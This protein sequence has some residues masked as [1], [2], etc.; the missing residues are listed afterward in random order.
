MIILTPRLFSVVLFPGIL[1]FIFTD[2]N[3]KDTDTGN[4]RF[5]PV[6]QPLY[7]VCLFVG[8]FVIEWLC[9]VFD[10]LPLRAP[11]TTPALWA[12]ILHICLYFTLLLPLLPLLRRRCSARACAMLWLL[13]NEF[14]FLAHGGTG[15]PRPLVVLPIAAD[16]T[17]FLW[18]WGVGAGPQRCCGYTPP[19]PSRFWTTAWKTRSVAWHSSP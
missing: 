8:N 4:N 18:L 5:L 16:L 14:F 15:L 10:G 19:C 13:P 2:R 9:R 17:V 7:L 3:R 11:L 12:A 1:W 6:I